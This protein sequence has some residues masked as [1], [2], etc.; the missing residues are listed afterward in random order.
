MLRSQN[1]I[2]IGTFCI[3][4][5]LSMLIVV[6][7]IDMTNYNHRI[8]FSQVF[9]IDLVFQT[10]RPVVASIREDIKPHNTMMPR[11]NIAIG[12]GITTNKIPMDKINSALPLFTTLLPSFCETASL[13][14][15][16]HF[17][18]AHDHTDA[19]FSKE[20]S[21][22]NFTVSF[23]TL[24]K[25]HCHP[26]L[27]VLLH[28]VNCGH[29]GKPA[30]A[31]NDAMMAAYNDSMDYYYRVNDDTKMKSKNWTEVFIRALSQFNPP[32]VGVV[33]PNHQGGNM[34]ILTYDFVH[35][36]HV[37]IFGFYYPRNFT[38]WYADDWITKVYQPDKSRKMNEIIV[39]H[40]MSV[41]TRYNIASIGG[42]ILEKQL[43]RDKKTLQAW[44]TKHSSTRAR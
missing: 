8:Q 21:H 10:N 16:Y 11:I 25:T 18:L 30:W 9:N 28:F 43:E 2:L 19:F 40:T 6:Y 26:S 42:Q 27:P 17:Y 34:A 20:G 44:L 29:S 32:N 35:K 5:L 12:L 24:V 13:G 7:N 41:G 3:G 31:Q 33:G 36:T 22:K 1:A 23:Y 4:L 39:L 14:Y 15:R 37:D 38:T